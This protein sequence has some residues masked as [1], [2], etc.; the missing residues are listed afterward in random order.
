MHRGGADLHGAGAEGDELRRVAPGGDAADAGDR[1]AAPYRVARDLGH[2]AQRDR[3]HRRPAIAAMR[4]LAVHHRRRRHQVEIDTEMID[5]MVLISETASAPPRMR[6]ARRLQNVGDV[7]RQLHDHRHPRVLLA[8]ARDHLDVFGHLADGRAHAALAH[9]V[10]AAEIQL[11]AVRAGVL[12]QRQDRL[13]GLLPSH[14]TIRLTTMAR[15]GQSR[16]TCLI[17]RRFTCQRPVGDQLDI[18]EARRPG[19]PP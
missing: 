19:A 16:L 7:R 11:D 1:Q 6:R 18:V 17:S 8:P 15:S 12:H 5:M 4:A 10:R 13:P 9:A 3:L 14:G 2:H